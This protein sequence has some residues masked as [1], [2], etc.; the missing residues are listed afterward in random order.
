MFLKFEFLFYEDD[1][2]CK[3][4]KDCDQKQRRNP[5]KQN[6]N[7]FAKKRKA[8]AYAS[9]LLKSLVSQ[10]WRVIKQSELI[11]CDAYFSLG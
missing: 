10:V 1:K 8:A 6:G 5:G 4:S 9:F 11:K 3:E 2:D 7:N